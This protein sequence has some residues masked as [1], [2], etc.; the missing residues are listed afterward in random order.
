MLTSAYLN[1]FLKFLLHKLLK[2]IHLINFIPLEFKPNNLYMWRRKNKV[3]FLIIIVL[4]TFFSNIVIAQNINIEYAY[5]HYTIQDGLA[6]MQVQ[7]LFQDSKGYLWCGTKIGISRFDGKNFKNYTAYNITKNGP[8]YCF[9]EDKNNNIYIFNRN[10]IS[11]LEKNAIVTISYPKGHFFKEINFNSPSF[12]IATITLFKKNNCNKINI[13]HYENPDSLYIEKMN[14]VNGNIYYFDEID[15]NI[16]WTISQDT[17]FKIDLTKKAILKRFKR[18]GIKH[19]KRRKNILYGFSVDEGIFKLVNNRFEPVI[20]YQFK[21]IDIKAITTPDEESFIIKT[22]NNLYIF[23]DEVKLIKGDMT[24]IRDILF[25]KEENLWV[26]TEE[27]LYNFFK[28]NFVNYTFG[29][30]NKDW[31]WSIVEDDKKNMWFTSFQNGIWKWNGKTITDYTKILDKQRL[32]I[33]YYSPYNYFMGAS[34][35]GEKLYFTTNTNVIK[36]ENNKFTTIEETK[37][38]DDKA[39]FITK[40]VN[41][42]ILYCGGMLGLLE[43]NTSGKTRFWSA[44]SLGIS[45]I[46]SVE[47]TDNKTITAIG[48]N[49]IVIIEDDTIAY[50]SQTLHKNFCSTK[51]HHNNI[52]IGGNQSLK[53]LSRDSL[54]QIEQKDSSELFF[55]ILF[56]KPHHLLLGGLNGLYVAN[57]EDYYKNNIFEPVLYNHNNGFTGIECGQNGFFTDS[58]GFVWI[59]TSDLVTRFDPQKLINKEITPPS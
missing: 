51:D 53:L 44:D 34:R 22:R 9:H 25:D 4:E 2:Q 21:G 37:A 16:V 33:H 19:F 35:A 43:I 7:S 6:Q 3:I 42:S 32:S 45:T 12:P 48:S 31:V 24:L 28:L 46:L 5:K 36:Y 27:G 15:K 8:V 41:D 17:I 30:G 52:W 18:N 47:V 14:T 56:V 54:K 20:K 11:R 57:L 13:L 29:M 38:P 10:S 59:N 26:A 1:N 58:E 50:R 40:T 55:S 23:T 49:G 39:F